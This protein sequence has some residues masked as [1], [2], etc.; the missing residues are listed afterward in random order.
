VSK[1]SRNLVH[2]LRDNWTAL[3]TDP[4]DKIYALLGLATD[5]QNPQIKADYTLSKL[6]TY[7]TTMDYLLCNHGNLDLISYSG[8]HIVLLPSYF[9][10]VPSVRPLS[11]LISIMAAQLLNS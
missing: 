10:R 2:L 4:R 7:L 11:Y 9:Y 5:C 6:D 1:D 3:A 8:I